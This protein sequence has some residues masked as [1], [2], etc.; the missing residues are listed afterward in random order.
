MD[1]QIDPQTGD[2]VR[3][4]EAIYHDMFGDEYPAL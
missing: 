1:L 2:E 3:Q 4:I